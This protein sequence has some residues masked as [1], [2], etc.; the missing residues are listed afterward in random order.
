[1]GPEGQRWRRPEKRMG[2]GG[3]RLFSL[4]WAQNT[5]WDLHKCR[6]DPT[7]LGAESTFLT[8]SP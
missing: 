8:G 5:T 2:V 4:G 6:S 1:M 3:S 7:R